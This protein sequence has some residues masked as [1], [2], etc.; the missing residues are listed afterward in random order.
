[1]K[2]SQL[3]IIY[4]SARLTI[5]ETESYFLSQLVQDQQSLLNADEVSWGHKRIAPKTWAGGFGSDSKAQ[6]FSTAAAIRLSL[7][8]FIKPSTVPFMLNLGWLQ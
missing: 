2:F 1:L 5:L 4:L 6:K 7:A 8:M 3:P